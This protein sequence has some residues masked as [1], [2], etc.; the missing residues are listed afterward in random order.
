MSAPAL[1]RPITGGPLRAL[2]GSGLQ[3]QA[4]GLGCWPLAGVTSPGVTEASA[5][6]TVRAWLDEGLTFLD[7][8]HGYGPQGESDRRIARALAGRR[9]QATIA[10]KVGMRIDGPQRSIDGTPATLRRQCEESLQRLRTDRVDLLY[11]HQ[12][13]PKVPVEESAGTLA[14]LL[15]AGKTRAVGLSNCTVAELR[16]F[17]TACPVVAVQLPYNLITRGIEEELVPFCRAHDVA[18]VAYWPLMKGLLGGRLVAGR[19]IPPEDGRAKYPLFQGPEL[20][21]RL[22]AVDRLRALAARAGLTVAQL[23]L[24][25]TIHRPGITAAVVGA[26]RPEQARENAGGLGPPLPDEVCR[27][28]EAALADQDQ[29]P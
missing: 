11:L 9:D 6:A 26:R 16:R 12:P 17:A 3:V 15:A 14:A 25:W 8:A 24:R 23:V 19:P 1:A 7:T 27:A 18:V 10:I 2:G 13:D 21:R 29:R 4:L 5:C 20:L 28:M 22:G